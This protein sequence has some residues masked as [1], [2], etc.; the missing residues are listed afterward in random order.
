MRYKACYINRD[1]AKLFPRLNKHAYQRFI[2]TL[3]FLS[4][5]I[6]NKSDLARNLEISQKTITEYLHIAEQTFIWRNINYDTYSK[7]KSLVK[8]S[9][10]YITDSGLS[11]YLLY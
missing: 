6:I 8:N 9:K 7:T 1:I 11:H 4:G 2:S 3:S 5:K 10:G